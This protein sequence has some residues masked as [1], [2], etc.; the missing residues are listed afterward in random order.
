MA[1]NEVARHYARVLLEIVVAGG[2]DLARVA[3]GL[4]AVAA[5]IAS[6]SELRRIL[7]S[8]ALPRSRRARLAT[9][10]ADRVLPGTDPARALLARF[11]AVMVERERADLVPDTAAA[12]RSAAD[13]R[14]NTFEAEVVS[15]RRLDKAARTSLAEALQEAL[16][17]K[18]RLT[19]RED[20]T[21][22]G[23]FRI[24]TGNR[25][26]DASV[27]SELERFA[28]RHGTGSF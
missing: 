3:D 15:A 6:S 11:L 24:R 9:A 25:I 27:A 23:G 17:G 14:E 2:H 26:Y 1:E 4:E 7:A 12:F 10:V 22:I 13:S 28:E 21:L 8:P 16:S 5:A 20:R 19:F 18:A